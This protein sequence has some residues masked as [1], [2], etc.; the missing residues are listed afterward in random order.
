MRSVS[1]LSFRKELQEA[2]GRWSPTVGRK[3]S[4]VETAGRRE[5]EDVP[6][7]VLKRK[8]PPDVEQDAHRVEN[9]ARQHEP[10]GDRRK[11][12]NAL[13]HDHAAPTEAEIKNDRN[14]IEPARQ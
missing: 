5:D 14:A 13:P 11:L 8:A 4:P 12:R 6:D 3:H 9:A 7:G 10:Q 2:S 1:T